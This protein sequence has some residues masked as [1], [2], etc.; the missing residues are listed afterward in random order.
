MVRKRQAEWP[1][2]RVFMSEETLSTV[3]A[4]EPVSENMGTNP[5][6]AA[7]KK[8]RFVA[9][10][11]ERDGQAASFYFNEE[12]EEW[13]RAAGE[14]RLKRVK[15]N[16][17]VPTEARRR[18]EAGDDLFRQSLAE[19][20]NGLRRELD[21]RG[22][23]VYFDI[24]KGEDASAPMRAKW[25][26][27][28]LGRRVDE[29]IEWDALPSVKE[30]IRVSETNKHLWP[31]VENA[32]ADAVPSEEPPT[33]VAD[34]LRRLRHLHRKYGTCRYYATREWKLWFGKA[35]QAKRDR[36][37]AG[38]VQR[39]CDERFPEEPFG[40]KEPPPVEELDAAV[41]EKIIVEAERLLEGVV[42]RMDLPADGSPESSADRHIAG[43]A[44]SL[45]ELLSNRYNAQC[46][47]RTDRDAI[48]SLVAETLE[49]RR[50]IREREAARTESAAEEICRRLESGAGSFSVDIGSA[51]EGLEQVLLRV[52][53]RF[54]KYPL[55]GPPEEAEFDSG[56]VEL[57]ASRTRTL[58]SG[59]AATAVAEKFRD[60]VASYDPT[61]GR[62]TVHDVRRLEAF[63]SRLYAGVAARAA[64]AAAGLVPAR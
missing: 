1:Y 58:A 47:R 49:R 28:L 60:H 10:R 42:G 34:A 12:F 59:E 41:R 31:R 19:F 52:T 46:E 15:A 30:M 22:V 23:K 57:I 48:A 9:Y 14:Y 43:L 54:V 35:M 40:A 13:D 50:E 45:V 7:P 20:C 62:L 36:L 55:T 37:I 44:K 4:V 64:A 53:E 3:S 26:Y 25:T 2:I 17:A 51:A 6:E 39:L 56:A 32:A 61:T 5:S 63:V 24:P 33:D 21:G 8:R 18:F 38:E 16:I 29:T 11:L 27:F